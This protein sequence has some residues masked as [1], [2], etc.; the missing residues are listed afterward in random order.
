M[1]LLKHIF[2]SANNFV[3]IKVLEKMAELDL[4]D[5]GF[6]FSIID[7]GGFLQRKQVLSLLVKSPSSRSK[8]AQMLLDIP[9]PFGLKGK[10]IEENLRLVDEVPFPEAKAYLA[11]LSK[12][13]FFWNRKIRIKAN[14]ILKKDGV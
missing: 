9:N 5:E 3:K 7:E 4:G 8:I 13:R 10:V 6:L 2:S 1:L 14:K 12:Y 11:A